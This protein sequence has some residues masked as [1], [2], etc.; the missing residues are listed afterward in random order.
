V[1]ARRPELETGSLPVDALRDYLKQHWIDSQISYQRK[2]SRRQGKFDDWLVAGTGT[3]FVLTLIAALAYSVGKSIPFLTFLHHIPEHWTNV[4]LVV[5][6]TVPAIGAAL[7]G[8]GAQRQFRRHSERY[9]TMANVLEKVHADM[10]DA[11]T[12][13]QVRGVAAETEQV[14]REE[15]SDWFGV[16]RFHDM[17]LIT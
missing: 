9:R 6:I 11:T 3:L 2:A 4:L 16:M 10:T 14:M 8:I 7:H 5:S 17:K 12:I 13:D 15:N 1:S